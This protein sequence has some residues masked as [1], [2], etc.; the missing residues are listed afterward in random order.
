MR[1]SFASTIKIT[2]EQVNLVAP[3]LS[4]E[5]RERALRTSHQTIVGLILRRLR[6]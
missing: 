3:N 6:A 1:R 4:R 5:Q 2:G